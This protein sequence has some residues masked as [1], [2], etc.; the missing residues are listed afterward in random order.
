MFFSALFWKMKNVISLRHPATKPE[1]WES[2]NCLVHFLHTWVLQLIKSWE[3]N[4]N[5][6]AAS[7]HCDWNLNLLMEHSGDSLIPFLSILIFPEA[8]KQSI[9]KS[10]GIKFVILITSIVTHDSVTPAHRQAE[11]LLKLKRHARRWR[12]KCFPSQL[13]F[14]MTT[15]L[16]SSLNTFHNNFV[17]LCFHNTNWIQG[18]TRDLLLLQSIKQKERKKLSKKEITHWRINFEWFFLFLSPLDFDQ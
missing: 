10:N 9:R 7:S 11:L 5:D 4:K 13:T 15:K 18:V 2:I 1:E 14:T 3:N 8:I 16:C 17:V 12:W 6:D